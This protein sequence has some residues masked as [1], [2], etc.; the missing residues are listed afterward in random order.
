MQDGLGAVQRIVALGASSDIARATLERL[1]GP[2]TEVVVLAARDA[3]RL[4]SLA[5]ALQARGAKRV[6]RLSF[7]ALEPETHESFVHEAFERAGGDV[8]LVL[9]TFGVLGDQSAAEQDAAAAVAI[10]RVNYVGA[11]SVLVPVSTK[12]RAQGHGTIVALSSVAGERVRRSNFIYGSSKAGLDAFLQGLGDELVGSGVRVMIVRPGFVHSHMT[13]GL[14]PAPL[15][16]TPEDVG[17]AIVT[18]LKAGREIVWVPARL[19]YVMSVLRHLPRPVFR[20]M[21]I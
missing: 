13:Q 12:L 19:R 10:T 21:P 8:D 16:V 2:R 15:A 11:V 4:G 14:E 20:R 18:G 5:D 7:D 1:V 9:V 6:E 17:D 3:D